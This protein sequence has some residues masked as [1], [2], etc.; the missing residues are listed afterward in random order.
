VEGS[1]GRGVRLDRTALLVID[2]QIGFIE[3][4]YPSYCAHTPDIIPNVNRLIATCR[5]AGMRIIFTRHTV[6]DEAPYAPPRLAAGGS[7]FP[8]A[9]RSISRV[10]TG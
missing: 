7:L 5:G 1:C 3:Q 2:M 10:N 6:I 4:G 8:E 9:G